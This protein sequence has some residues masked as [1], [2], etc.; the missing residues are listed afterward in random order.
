MANKYKLKTNNMLKCAACG[1][2]EFEK[3]KKSGSMFAQ[4]VDW[5]WNL[6]ISWTLK[7]NSQEGGEWAPL[8]LCL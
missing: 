8:Y 2:N 1:N 5:W 6:L 3:E 7:V 4:S